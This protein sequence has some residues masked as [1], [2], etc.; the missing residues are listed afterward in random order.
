M[1]WKNSRMLSSS[2][3]TRILQCAMNHL[4]HVQQKFIYLSFH[5]RVE[6]R[7]KEKGGKG[8]NR[9]RHRNR[10]TRD[11]STSFRSSFNSTSIN[12]QMTVRA[13]IVP[14]SEGIAPGCTT[15]MRDR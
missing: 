9:F 13:T 11:S 10:S 5:W 14:A 2:S 7:R 12:C 15:G 8:G 4:E 6:D 3:T 1:I